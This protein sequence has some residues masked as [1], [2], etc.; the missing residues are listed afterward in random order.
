MLS[1]LKTAMRRTGIQPY[2]LLSFRALAFVMSNRMYR[3]SLVQASTT[4]MKEV[5]T[6]SRPRA[7]GERPNLIE[8]AASLFSRPSRV[9]RPFS[10]E[11]VIP[12]RRLRAFRFPKFL[13]L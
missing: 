13:Y 9:L 5:R 11:F 12:C 4:T 2:D 10:F 7:D 8:L 1:G 3:L 6:K